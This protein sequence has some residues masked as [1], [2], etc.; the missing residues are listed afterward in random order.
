MTS[1]GKPA[2]RWLVLFDLDG[3][4]I[5]SEPGITACLAHAFEQIGAPLPPREILR[6]WI[7]PPFR[8]TF[9]SV[10]GDDEARIVAAI[11]HYRDRF[12][13]VGW[14]EHAIY[15]G[16]PELIAAL[17]ARGDALAVVTT[18]PESQARRIV[19]HFA[20]GAAFARVYGPDDRHA[21][22]PKSAM[23]ADALAD[24]GARAEH[25]TMI[26]DRHFDIEGAR[27]N[28][29]RGLGVSWGFGS[30]EELRGAGADAIASLPHEL[31]TLL[32]ATSE[33]HASKTRAP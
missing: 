25:A 33:A 30:I 21:H 6:T 16:I 19:E 14:S 20:F 24:F 18:K 11:D 15:D 31:T 12:E 26:G 28:G 13:D 22:R 29:V 5:D 1:A 3:T 27:A 9:P 8:Q 17:A 10:L 23:I 4:L 2:S 32:G 7:G